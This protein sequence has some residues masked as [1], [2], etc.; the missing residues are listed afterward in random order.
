MEEKDGSTPPLHCVVCV[1]E[2]DCEKH[3]HAVGPCNHL[4]VCSLCYLRLRKLLK[5]MSC[6]LCKTEM[7]RVMVCDSESLRPFEDFHVWGDSA[8]PG[9]EWEEQSRMFLPKSYSQGYVRM[10]QEHRC[11]TEGCH[12]PKYDHMQGLEKHLREQ[13]KLY[14]CKVCLRERKVFLM[15]QTTY[16]RSQL[17]QHIR[18]GNPELGFKGHPRCE[19]CKTRYYNNTQLHQHL[20]KDHFSCHLCEKMGILHKV[21]D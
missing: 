16:T 20:V 1:E 21:H 18:Q 9:Y 15:E 13:H 5:E 7:D 19:F 2:I 10:L 6:V 17:D 11:H 14:F 4:G 3:L 8:G 12:H